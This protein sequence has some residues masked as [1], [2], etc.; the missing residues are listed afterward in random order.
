MAAWG[1]MPPASTLPGS[2]RT[3]DSMTLP[4]T[5]SNAIDDILILSSGVLAKAATNAAITTIAG[6]AL[7]ASGAIYASTSPGIGTLFGASTVGTVLTPGLPLQMDFSPWYQGIFIQLSLVQAIAATSPGTQVGLLL[8]GTTGYFVA[9]TSQGNK[10]GTIVNPVIQPSQPWAISDTG[11][12]VIVQIN[13]A[14]AI[15]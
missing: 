6:Q 8:D 15:G 5:G 13:A 12:R 1:Y 11:V 9:D 7:K 10:I 3:L 2:Q 14:T 4:F